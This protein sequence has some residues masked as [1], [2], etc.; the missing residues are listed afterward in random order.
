M[1]SRSIVRASAFS[2][3]VLGLVAGGLLLLAD[4]WLETPLAVERA[5]VLLIEK[6]LPLANVANRL[7][8]RG[9]LAHPRVFTWY[10]RVTGA[11]HRIHAGEYTITP[12]MTPRSLLDRLVR[13]DVVQ[14][15]LRVLEGWTVAQLLDVIATETSLVH[16]IT[17][18]TD[19]RAAL[20][21]TESSIEGMFF[22]DTYQFIGGSS[23]L[24]LLGRAYERMKA[25]LAS[26]WERRSADLPYRSPYEVL[27][28]ASIVEKETGRRDERPKIAQV[29]VSRLKQGMPLQTDPTVIYGLGGAF[30]GNLTRRHLADDTEF[31][32]YRRR[33]LPPTPI[34]LPG[35][36]SLEAAVH[37]AEGDYLYFVARGD[38]SSEFSATLAQHVAAVR[39]YQLKRLD[40]PDNP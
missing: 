6:G 12:G 20:G 10:A 32:T 29:F 35:R 28:M 8:A 2:V 16:E 24:D 5:E 39:R 13:G 11:A 27:I 30:D 40:E 21:V 36:A 31:N 34:A 37:P 9:T 33:G 14:H 3:F 38:G 26:A 15:E 18:D 7:A 25:E 22:P 4:R 23:D 1:P 17:A 19:L